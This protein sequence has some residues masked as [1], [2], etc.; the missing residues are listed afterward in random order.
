MDVEPAGP[1]LSAQFEG[2]LVR[3]EQKAGGEITAGKEFF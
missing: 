3:H 1:W 2:E